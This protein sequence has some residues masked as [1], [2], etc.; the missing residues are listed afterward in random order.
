MRIFI[1]GG[2]GVIGSRLIRSLSR[3]GNEVFCTFL[4]HPYFPKGC[5]S[6]KLDIT[7]R[8][9]TIDLITRIKPEITIHT[10]ALTNVDLCE[11]DWKLANKINIEGTKNVVDAC[12]KVNSKIVYIS[13]SNIFDGKKKVFSEDDKP[14]PINYY[15]FTKLVG[16]KMV[17]SSQLPFLILRTDQPYSWVEKW[18]RKSFVMWVLEKLKAGKI[19]EVFMDW[20][21]NP[22]FLDDFIGITNELIKKEKEGTYHIVGSDFL[23]RYKW[24][25]KIAKIFGEDQN[26]I[27]PA[28]SEQSELPAK[29]ANANLSNSKIQKEIGI[30]PLGVE[31]GLK[32]MLKQRFDS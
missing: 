13:T 29:R 21:N 25:L 17:V 32:L 31:E 11:T 14:N 15:G 12:R 30:K 3:N 9:P 4:T 8:G 7:E 5:T 19:V 26:L 23:N 18:Q 22:T 24:A 28:R 10:S 16:E 6:Y 20:Y 2:S 1:S 27:H